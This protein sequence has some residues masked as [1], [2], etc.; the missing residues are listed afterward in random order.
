MACRQ[1]IKENSEK[2]GVK[3][4]YWSDEMLA[5][6]E[7]AWKEVV[8][9]EI[10]KDPMFKK[11]GKTWNSSGPNIRNGRMW[12]FYPGKLKSS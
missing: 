6:F 7:S 4:L 10:A 11:P 2:H 9:E 5:A 12:D 1:I 3:N 8:Q